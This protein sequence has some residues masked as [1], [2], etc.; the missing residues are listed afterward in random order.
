MNRFQDKIT[1]I[2]GA[3]TGIGLATVRRIRAEGGMIYA[4]VLSLEAEDDFEGAEQLILDV[5]DEQQWQKAIR[6]ILE[7]HGRLDVLI[8]NAG[9]R[10][11]NPIED[12][13]IEQWQRVINVNL[14][15]VFLGCKAALPALQQSESGAIVNLGS[16]T[17]IRSV[18][19]MIAYSASKSGITALTSSLAIDLAKDNIRVNAVCPG[20]IGTNMV[21]SLIDEAENSDERE[22]QIIASHPLGRI[23]RPDEVASVIAFLASDDASF[24]TGLSIPVDGG[25]SIR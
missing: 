24:M 1:L 4:G 3:A 12:T 11:S 19:N 14:S 2:T 22:A 23:G 9:I 16:I 18:S 5:T 8:N 21:T 10:E 6:H 13:S 25:R 20:A 7:K 15:S 17:G